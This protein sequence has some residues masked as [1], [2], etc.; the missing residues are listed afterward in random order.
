MLEM[1]INPFLKSFVYTFLDATIRGFRFLLTGLAQVEQ[2]LRSRNIQF[3]LLMGA[4]PDVLPDFVKTNNIGGVVCDFAP[5]KLP[6]EWNDRVAK[7]LPPH[8]PL[9]Q[10]DAHNVIP[11]WVTSDKQEFAARTIRSKIYRHLS[12]YL[13][14]FPPVI[15]H[16]YSA[17]I[18]AERVNWTEA[19]SF[20][21]CDR[22]VKEIKW[23]EPGTQAA[24]NTL[25]T[26]L[27]KRLHSYVQN[28][29]GPLGTLSN[30]SP[31]FHFGQ[32]APARA[33]L[34]ELIID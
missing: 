23:L 29:G 30:M 31:Y 5:L 14:H 4:P 32:I 2:E 26:F 3:H 24:F 33:I 6:L 9:C 22:T 10:V 34:G 25:Y 18:K 20:L 1:V 12:K 27:T 11:C 15:V 28:H 21:E 19:D 7:L 16:P 17:D 8:V 13:T